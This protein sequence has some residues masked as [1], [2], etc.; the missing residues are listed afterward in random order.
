MY[1]PDIEWDYDKY[2]TKMGLTIDDGCVVALLKT[3]NAGKWVPVS[4]LNASH[5]VRISD[6]AHNNWHRLKDKANIE[7]DS[8]IHNLLQ[9]LSNRDELKEVL[10][11]NSSLKK[12]WE[13]L[14]IQI[15][16]AE[17]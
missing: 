14:L 3:M 7:F 6:Y 17:I 12:Q 8:P 2:G 13:D 15:K 1:Q 10:E 9:S 5:S 4:H 16:L 11:S